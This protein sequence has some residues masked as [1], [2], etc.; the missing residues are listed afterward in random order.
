MRSSVLQITRSK[1]KFDVS[2]DAGKVAFER[3]ERKT[4]RT[5][6]F[7]R[8]NGTLATKGNTNP[9]HLVESKINHEDGSWGVRASETAA[10]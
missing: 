8:G 10:R 1:E 4:W 7:A 6:V 5:R 3:I 2:F 9:M